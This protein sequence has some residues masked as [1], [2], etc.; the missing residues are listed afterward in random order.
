MKSEIFFAFLRLGFTA[1]GG[2]VAHIGYFRDEF[3]ARRKWLTDEAYADVVALCQ[4][5]PGPAS[6]QVGL[7]IG[8]LRAGPWGAFAAWSGFTLPS[9]VLMTAAALSLL[10]FG[11]AIP[12]GLLEGLKA[13]VVAVVAHALIG[14]GKSLTPDLPRLALAVLA[15]AVTLYIGGASGQLIAIGTGLVVGLIAFRT[16]VPPASD[17]PDF[18]PAIPKPVSL[19]LLVAFALLLVG[20]PLAAAQD[21]SLAMQI[22]DGFYRSGALVFGG[23]HVVLPLLQAETVAPGLVGATEFTAGYGLA[24][25]V[26]GPLFTFSAFLGGAAGIEHGPA[27][28]SLFALLALTMIF[29]PGAL[30]VAATL[31]FWTELRANRTARAALNGVNAAVVGILAAA[32][33]T[34]VTTTAINDWTDIAIAG[35]AFV[36]LALLRWPAWSVVPLGAGLGIAAASVL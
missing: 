25:A 23:G 19:A 13:V 14:M 8:M 5:L 2:P 18:A 11:D 6:S 27:A 7:A 28:A 34:P 29:L 10:Q 16:A 1:F 15:T 12:A 24:Q 30:L 20:L 33:Y 4:F 9:A 26:P 31:P 21:Q 36:A 17:A 35:L 3:V 22:A 32:L